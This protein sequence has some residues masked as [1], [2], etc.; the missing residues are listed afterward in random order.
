[1]VCPLHWT[2]DDNDPNVGGNANDMDCD[3]VPASDCDDNDASITTTNSNDGDC[4]GVPTLDR[5][6][7][8]NVEQRQR[9]DCDGVPSD[10]DAMTTTP[11]S[12]LPISAT[13][14]TMVCPHWT[15]TITML[16]SPP[17]VGDAD[18]DG[19]PTAL[20]CDDNDP[21]KQRQRF[22]LTCLPAST[23][24][25]TTPTSPAPMSMTRRL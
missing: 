2:G 9:F 23:A 11:T 1:M 12:P 5:D 20:D 8:P 19:V 24:M 18:C 15:V 4:D 10:I 22:G 16:P 17:N 21:S 25:T 7:N 13:P 6:D 14:T 3:G